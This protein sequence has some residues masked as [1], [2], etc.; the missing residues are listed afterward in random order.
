MNENI[1]KVDKAILVGVDIGEFDIEKSL[2][3][4]KELSITAGVDPVFTIYQK[5]KEY[6]KSTFI[7]SGKLEEII[8]ISN[9]YEIDLLI[10][11]NELTATQIKNIENVT[12][13]RVIDRT[14]LILDIFAQRAKSKEGI[15]QV[16]LAQQKY[17][18][19]RL[20]GIGS[21]LSRLKAG[22]GARGPGE[23]KL[24][25]D[26]RIIRERISFLKKEL[27]DLEKRRELRRKRRKKD[28]I[29]VVSIAGYTNVGKSTLLNC[30]TKSDVLSEDKL[31]ATLDPTSRY[32]TLPDGRNVLLV[33]TVGL[34]SRLPHHL[35]EAFKSTL[36]EISNSNLI[37]HVLDIS[38]PDFYEQKNVT[39]QILKDLNCSDIPVIYVYNKCDKIKNHDLNSSKEENSVFI[40]AKTGIGLDNLLQLI[41]DNINQKYKRLNILIPYDKVG[42]IAEIRK[43]GSIYSEE[44]LCDGIKIDALVDNKIIYMVSNYILLT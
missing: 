17:R 38:N 11:D 2:E 41:Q 15:L 37:L 7:G 30:L 35:I 28:D 20:S 10:F 9:N 44:Y 6:D 13:I 26:K 5:R 4:L 32:L 33:D 25:T 12:N 24:E 31:F 21:Q 16:E 22:V 8:D 39:D 14:M 27:S 40:S 1:E 29:I 19:P 43:T 42:I 23:T 36:E 3:E 18:L 34:I